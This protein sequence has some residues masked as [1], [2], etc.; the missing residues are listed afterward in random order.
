MEGTSSLKSGVSL[1]ERINYGGAFSCVLKFEH[2]VLVSTWDIF[3]SIRGSKVGSI[4]EFLLP[5][6]G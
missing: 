6:Q 5:L 1:L 4:T 2:A 3:E